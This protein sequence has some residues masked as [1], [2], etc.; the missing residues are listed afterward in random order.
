MFWLIFLIFAVA[1]DGIT[2]QGDGNGTSLSINEYQWKYGGTY[3]AVIPAYQ[4]GEFWVDS[5]NHRILFHKV[6]AL[7]SVRG[8]YWYHLN[9]VVK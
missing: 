1:T 9:T 6:D 5:T 2:V 7:V 3:N 8:M 4:S